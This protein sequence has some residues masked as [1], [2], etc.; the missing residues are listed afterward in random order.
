MNGKLPNFLIIGAAKAGTTSIHYYL[1]QHPEIYMPEKKET[2]FLVE[3]KSILGRGPGRFG[4]NL[5]TQYADYA[6]LFENRN[7]KQHKCR[8]EACVA[9]SYFYR[10]TIPNVKKYLKTPK[11]IIV[12]RDPTDR[13]FSN[14]LHHVR[15]GLEPL[16]FEDALRAEPQRRKWWWGFQL[17][18]VGFYHRQVK[19]YMESFPLV[20]VCL[21]DDLKK[22]TLALVRDIYEFL[23]VDSAFTPDV[24]VKYNVTGVP[25]SKLLHAFLTRPMLLK[26]MIKPIV[27]PFVPK[28]TRTRFVN[29]LKAKYLKKPQM[30]PET[31]QYLQELYREDILQLQS[32]IGRDLSHWLA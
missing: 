13:A 25:R 20:T 23:E 15:D 7:L 21:Y 27:Y 3:P 8:G 4:G 17:T 28:D 16:S 14:Y 1:K 31:R 10:N 29:R 32:L 22:D 9:Y 12:L 5:V 6:R 26:K 11:I 19:A 30:K 18:D 24:R 2:F